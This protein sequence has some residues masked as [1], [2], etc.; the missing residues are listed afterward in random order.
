M[1]SEGQRGDAFPLSYGDFDN[2]APRWSPDGK[3]IVFISNRRGTTSL[4]TETVPGGTQT[5]LVAKE[6]PLI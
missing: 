4:W 2:V 1:P 5:P 6:K 3:R